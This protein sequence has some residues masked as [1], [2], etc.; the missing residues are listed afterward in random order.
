MRF[1][2]RNLLQNGIWGCPSRAFGLPTAPMG[3]PWRPGTTLEFPR[4]D[5]GSSRGPFWLHF[6]VHFGGILGSFLGGEIYKVF[7]LFLCWV[8]GGLGGLLGPKMAHFGSLGVHRER[9]GEI[10]KTIFLLQ[11]NYGF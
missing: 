1:R 11:E 3:R 4:L 2:L 8:W 9:K 7:R 6:G 5:F 10:A